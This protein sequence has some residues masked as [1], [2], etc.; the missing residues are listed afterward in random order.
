M[1]EVVGNLKACQ[2]TRL[3]MQ[4]QCAARLVVYGVLCQ[5]GKASGAQQRG[6]APS[7]RSEERW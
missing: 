7:L 1:G 4:V 6:V 3:A 2:Q 5:A